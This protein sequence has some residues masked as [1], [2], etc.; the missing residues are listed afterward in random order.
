MPGGKNNITPADAV[1]FVKGDARINRLGQPKK[2]N[3]E[4]LLRKVLG[5]KIGDM[6]AI[7][8]ILVKLKDMAISGDIRAAELL[9]DRAFGKVRAPVENQRPSL[10]VGITYILPDGNNSKIYSDP[11]FSI[12]SSEVE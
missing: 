2:M 10:V 5:E 9:L 3:L 12:R 8:A 11:T 1:P 7:E 6:T 4:P